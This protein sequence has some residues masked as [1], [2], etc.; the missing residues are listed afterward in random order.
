MKKMYQ[1]QFNTRERAGFLKEFDLNK[2]G[3]ITMK[4]IITKLNPTI[5]KEKITEKNELAMRRPRHYGYLDPTL[6]SKAKERKKKV[7]EAI[8]R[9][10]L[11]EA[12]PHL[13]QQQVSA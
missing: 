5:L 8:E 10:Y 1:K 2:D 3:N 11:K 6:A 13:E 9:K 12:E 4:E 7:S